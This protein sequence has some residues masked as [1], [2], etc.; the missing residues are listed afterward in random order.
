M[1]EL[2]HFILIFPSP[3][4]TEKT[5]VPEESLVKAW[6]RT[7]ITLPSKLQTHFTVLEG[8]LSSLP[9]DRLQCDCVVSPANSFGIMDGGLAL[10]S[11]M[12]TRRAG[13][14]GVRTFTHQ[15]QR[16]LHA[17]WRHGYIPPGSCHITPLPSDVAGSDANQFGAS[18]IAVVPTMRYPVDIRW[19]QDLVYNA[20]WSLLVEVKRWN[21]ELVERG[22][23]N[24]HHKIERILM[25]GL[26]K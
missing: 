11:K 15:V 20:V 18:S 17:R 8:R 5:P 7:I 23:G 2:P 1:S 10:S 4:T 25:T 19:H 6:T 26:G 9:A 12:T 16:A 21:A 14:D 13:A 22:A 3:R 24:T